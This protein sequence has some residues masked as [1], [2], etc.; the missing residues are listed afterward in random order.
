MATGQFIVLAVIP[1]HDANDTQFSLKECLHDLLFLFNFCSSSL[2]LVI[3][4]PKVSRFSWQEKICQWLHVYVIGSIYVN[5]V[6]G[7]LYVVSVW[8]MRSRYREFL[9]CSWILKKLYSCHSAAFPP[10]FTQ[11]IPAY[12]QFD[13]IKLI[14]IWRVCTRPRFET[15]AKSSSEMAKCWG[16]LTKCSGEG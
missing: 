15:E 6:C 3:S 8:D 14:F 5:I 1:Y 9:C 12:V 10:F 16:N 13:A 7:G 11:L 2:S 4:S